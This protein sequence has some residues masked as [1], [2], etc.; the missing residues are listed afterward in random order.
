MSVVL[1]GRNSKLFKD[2]ELEFKTVIDVAI[3]HKDISNYKFIRSDSI[4]LLSYSRQKEEQR[5]LINKIKKINPR[6]LLVFSS[7]SC[8]VAERY[9]CYSYPTAKLYQERIIREIIPEAKILRLGTVVRKNNDQLYEGILITEISH[10][11]SFLRVILKK[12]PKSKMLSCYSLKEFINKKTMKYFIYD[13]YC[14]IIS[15]LPYPCLL[16]PVDLFIK[17]LFRYKWYGYGALS[18]IIEKQGNK[19]I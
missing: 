8:L 7:C 6:S 15:R 14:F 13:V 9:R 12:P 16:R 4:I 19:I 10:L 5:A 11:I 2:F 1:I 17:F 3:S 18:V